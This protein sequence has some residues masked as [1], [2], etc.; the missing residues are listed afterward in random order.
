MGI[1]S[2]RKSDLCK[3]RMSGRRISKADL[4]PGSIFLHDDIL[5]KGACILDHYETLTLM[6]SHL[7][8]LFDFYDPNFTKLFL[9]FPVEVFCRSF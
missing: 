1:G 2:S 6:R 5:P 3:C 7:S 4:Y 8:V 9:F